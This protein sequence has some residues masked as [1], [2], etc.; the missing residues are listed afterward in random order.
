[1]QNISKVHGIS[2]YKFSIINLLMNFEQI[3]ANSS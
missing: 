1:M 3:L 2:I